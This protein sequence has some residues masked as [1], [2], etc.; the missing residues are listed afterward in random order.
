M[1]YGT[2]G[3]HEAVA[4]H[5]RGMLHHYDTKLPGFKEVADQT[6]RVLYEGLIIISQYA[7]EG[8]IFD[9]QANR[10]TIEDACMNVVQFA[11]TLTEM[12][13]F[14]FF[15]ASLD[16]SWVAPQ[17]PFIEQEMDRVEG[18][19]EEVRCT[20]SL[21]LMEMGASGVVYVVKPKVILSES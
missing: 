20:I 1:K 14:G 4:R 21:G 8:F 11:V 6:R 17:T 16:V 13:K 12:I 10:K 9:T 7:G 2:G 19:S 3:E 18:G 5:W 15:S